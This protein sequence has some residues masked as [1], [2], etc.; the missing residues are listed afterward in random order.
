MDRLADEECRCEDVLG[1]GA[2]TPRMVGGSGEGWSLGSEVFG[3]VRRLDLRLEGTGGNDRAGDDGV[4]ADEECASD[5][6]WGNGVC[7][8][9]T[10]ERR[11]WLGTSDVRVDGN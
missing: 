6:S 2:G 9:R 1:R 4:D 5:A 11:A 10:R 3:R 7:L 8:S